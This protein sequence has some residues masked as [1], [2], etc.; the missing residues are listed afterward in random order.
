MVVWCIEIFFFIILFNAYN[1]TYVFCSKRESYDVA[2]KKVM[3]D[4]TDLSE[5]FAL[6]IPVSAQVPIP[7]PCMRKEH[8]HQCELHILFRTGLHFSETKCWCLGVTLAKK[9][10]PRSLLEILCVFNCPASKKMHWTSS[11][12]T[13][14]SENLHSLWGME[15]HF[16][17]LH[18][19][20]FE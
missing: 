19:W 11:R 20:S 6:M 5:I 14:M 3:V 16:G 17:D 13:I 10:R 15:L 12:H 7:W 8:E 18:G 9:A 4:P 2:N 1:F